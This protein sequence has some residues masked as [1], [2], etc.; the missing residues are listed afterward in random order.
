MAAQ[1]EYR[2]GKWRCTYCG[3]I[4][5]QSEEAA[6]AACVRVAAVTGAQKPYF[7]EK[8]GWWHTSRRGGVKWLAQWKTERHVE[9]IEPVEFILRDYQDA[10]ISAL[11]SHFGNGDGNPIAALPTG[12][13][14]SVII[15]AFIRSA[16]Q[17]PDQNILALTH[18]KELIVQNFET[19][20]QMWPTAPAGIY[21]AGLGRRDTTTP[22][23]FA[24]IQSVHKKPEIFGKVDLVIID[25]CHLVSPKGST[26][27]QK[28]IAALMEANPNLKVIGFTATQFRLGQGMLTDGDSLFDT[29]AFDLTEREA[30]N[31]MIANGWIS[32]LVPKQ[33][34]AIL[35]ISEV[36][37]QGGEFVLKELQAKV[38]RDSVTL[39]ALQEA[40]NLAADRKHWLVFASGIEHAEHVAGFLESHYDIEAAAVHSKMSDG[41]RDARIKAFKAGKIKA[42]V[43][44]NIL[45]TGFDFP[46]IDCIVMLRPTQ[47]PVLWVQMLGRGTR[48]APGKE[49]CLVLDFAGNTRRLGPINDPVLPRRKGKGP[50]GVAPVRLCENCGCYSHA[51]CR[52]CENPECGVEF[53]KTVKIR[54]HADTAALIAEGLPDVQEYE[55]SKVTYEIHKKRGKP[56][57]MRVTYYCGLRRFREYICLDHGGYAARVARQWW[58]MRSPWGIPPS[59]HDGMTAVEHLR[60]P[61]TISVIEKGKYPEIT[62]YGFN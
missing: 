53:P 20:I 5:F 41:E 37:I 27:Y 15:A 40:V 25:E 4:A 38:D 55:V 57:S 33:T 59:V 43:N 23:T 19:L 44:N 28:F 24:G 52:F 8:C 36:R 39:A 31:W 34:Q 11:Y 6:A 48:P 61:R 10:C 35:D 1:L 30:F 22:I 14:K 54:S 51:S 3:K 26:M 46:E 62:G 29:V 21:S 32:P 12:T 56:D 60:T 13:G 7:A 16:M 17:Y 2:R 58:E 42:L 50:K 18:V 45:T 47:S 9:R 49:N